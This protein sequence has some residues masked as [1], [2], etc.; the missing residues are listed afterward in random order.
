[1]EW[2][3]DGDL[4]DKEDEDSEWSTDALAAVLASQPFRVIDDVLK[5]I[6]DKR[7]N[8]HSVKLRRAADVTAYVRA[9]SEKMIN[10]DARLKAEE[11]CIGSH[12]VLRAYCSELKCP[13]SLRCRRTLLREM[14][15]EYKVPRHSPPRPRCVLHDST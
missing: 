14:I 1:M 12:E 4:E 8:A 5:V 11:I 3:S 7:F 10:V 2:D 13:C 6:T 9:A 15:T